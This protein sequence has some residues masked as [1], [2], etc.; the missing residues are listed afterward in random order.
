[1]LL[2]F[3]VI[4]RN[5]ISFLITSYLLVIIRLLFSIFIIFLTL[6]NDG[7]FLVDSVIIE[8]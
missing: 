4:R 1:M 7:V 3:V 2:I 6:S 5:G 8:S